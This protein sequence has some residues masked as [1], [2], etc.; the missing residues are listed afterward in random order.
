MRPNDLW[1][2]I[3]DS[4]TPAVLFDNFPKAF[5]VDFFALDIAPVTKQCHSSPLPY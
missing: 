2:T 1:Q 4:C 5:F 3:G